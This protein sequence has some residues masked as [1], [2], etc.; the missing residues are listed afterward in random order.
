MIG[1]ILICLEVS[2]D[3]ML[4]WIYSSSCPLNFLLVRS[5]QAEIIIVKRLI[6]GRNNLTR[7]RI[8]PESRNQGRRQNDAF[9][10]ST[11]LPTSE[12]NQHTV[13]CGW[14]VY[15]ILYCA[16]E[17]NDTGRNITVMEAL[18]YITESWE[19]TLMIT[20]VLLL[21][22]T[23]MISMCVLLMKLSKNATTKTV[24]KWNYVKWLFALS[25]EDC[26]V[27]TNEI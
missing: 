7:A 13:A 6:Q 14:F 16:I 25:N 12:K 2:S 4:L 11:T 27:E 23:L 21:I 1:G 26:F 9:T 3:A 8:E 17:I 10:Y 18:Q 20:C 15:L 22:L 5:H 24:E 19:M